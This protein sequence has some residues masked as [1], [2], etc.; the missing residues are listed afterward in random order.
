MTKARGLPFFAAIFAVAAACA[1]AQ[2][3]PAG[4]TTDLVKTDEIAETV[5]VFGQVVAGRQSDVATRVMGVVAEAP[6]NVGDAVQEGD[7]VFRLDPE[8]LEIELE[9]ARADL[10]I[11]EAGLLAAKA[12]ADRA[13][14][15]FERTQSLVGNSAVSEAQLDQSSGDYAEAL[16]NLQQAEAR[17]A[18][19]RAGLN[20][21]QYSLDN[22][23]VRAPF[24]GIVLSVSAEVGEFVNAGSTVVEL[25]DSNSLEVEANVPSRYVAT[26]Q[27]GQS[28]Q[29]STDAGADLLLK[30]RATLPTE[31]SSTRTRPVRFTMD[32]AA[33]PD[34]AVGQ[35]VTL[36]VPISVPV[37]VV[38]VPKDAVVQAGGG[39]QVFVN[40]G[41]KAAPRSIQIGRAIGNRFEVLSGLQ[42]GT[43]VVVRGNERLRPGQ[44]IAPT[45]IAANGG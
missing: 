36:D 5:T 14:K 3:R 40:D 26:L 30:V 16:G 43:E 22:A 11:A 34:V 35:S 45:P 23:V 7:V 39:W 18:A 28:V 37:E 27:A 6:L 33:S 29:A 8:R 21:A 44:D 24:A 1:T 10:N 9:Q 12:R 25:L 42:P 17:I 31:F 4:V 15:T 13:Q 41:G 38:V 20:G 32:G 19:S 2:G